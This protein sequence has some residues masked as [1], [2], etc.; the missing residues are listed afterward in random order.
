MA[1][2]GKML[3]TSN[4]SSERF[5]LGHVDDTDFDRPSSYHIQ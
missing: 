4:W 5:K 2:R 1:Q 3:K